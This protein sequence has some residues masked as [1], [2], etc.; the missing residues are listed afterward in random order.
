MKTL[1]LIVVSSF[2]AGCD[3]AQPT[4][5]SVEPS[6]SRL[7]VPR[8]TPDSGLDLKNPLDDGNPPVLA[9]WLD[10]TEHARY[11]NAPYLRIAVWE[12]GRVVFARDPRDWSHDLWLGR[13]PEQ[14][15]QTLKGK[16][17]ETG[18]FRLQGYCYLAWDLPTVCISLSFDHDQQMLYSHELG[19]GSPKPQHLA[20][21]HAWWEINRL[22][23]AALPDRAKKLDARF[24][25]PPTEWY[26]KRM[27]QSE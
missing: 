8:I 13:M 23:L 9:V 10:K 15:L 22:A 7:A 16:I 3:E 17:R 2:L 20:F 1:L 26:L 25:P 18:V 11:T 6:P 12:D 5:N 27:I 21:E 14:A 4:I 24:R 19:L